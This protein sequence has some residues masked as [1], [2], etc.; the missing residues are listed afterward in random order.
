MIAE[1]ERFKREATQRSKET[2]SKNQRLNEMDRSKE[3]R[4]E[5]KKTKGNQ[6]RMIKRMSRYKRVPMMPRAL[7]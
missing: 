2:K 3:K 1:M 5:L 4:G 7:N 6:A